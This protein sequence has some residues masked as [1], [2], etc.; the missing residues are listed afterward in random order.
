MYPPQGMKA[1]STLRPSA[2]SPRSVAGPSAITCPRFTPSPTFTIGFWLMQVFWFERWYLIRLMMS[3]FGPVAVVLVGLDHD[4][5]RV[6][7][8]HRAVALGDDGDAGVARDHGL[9]AGADERR[10]GAQQRHGLALHVRAHQRAVRVVVLEERD[11]ATPPPT[12]AGSATRPSSRPPRRHHPGTRRSCGR[13]TVS[14][15]K[16]LPLVERRVGL[17]DRE[18]LLLERREV[19]HL[20]ASRCCRAPRGTASR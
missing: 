19:L 9:H 6:D 11:R 4:A 17:R 8:H 14:F 10:L 18:P 13:V 2:S 12:P 1:T 20:V 5:A 15:T 7:R 3:T 16:R